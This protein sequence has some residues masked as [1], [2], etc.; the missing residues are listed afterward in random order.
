M[1]QRQFELHPDDAR[2]TYLGAVACCLLDEG[3]KALEWIERAV[4]M[5]PDEPVTQ[6]NAACVFALQGRVPEAIDCLQ[7][8]LKLGFAHKKWIERSR[9]VA[10]PHAVCRAA[11][12]PEK[13]SS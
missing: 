11:A 4:A 13:L 6:Y 3:A 9:F 5:D 7:R 12:E 1:V 2:A 8:A 10:L